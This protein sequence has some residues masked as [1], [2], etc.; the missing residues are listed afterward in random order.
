MSAQHPSRELVGIFQSR[1]Q[2]Q[3]AV[4][5]LLKVGFERSDLSVLASHSSL[6]AARPETAS[7][8]ERLTSLVGEL[9]YEGPLV[10]AGLIALASGPVGAALAGMVA[11]GV[12]AVALKEFWDEVTSTPDTKA[13]EA[14]LAAGSLIL[15]VAA[16]DDLRE[17]R[18]RAALEGFG[19]T[20]LHTVERSRKG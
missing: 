2:F 17:G 6:D 4:E 1:E 7:L 5:A 13:F 12:G 11:A 8:R 16:P 3:S 15:W 18:A 20:N 9:K 10:A 14:A 19:A